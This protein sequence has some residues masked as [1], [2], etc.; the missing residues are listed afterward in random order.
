MLCR[1]IRNL[2]LTV[3]ILAA[4]NADET[5]LAHGVG[6][7][8]LCVGGSLESGGWICVDEYGRNLASVTQNDFVF[9]L[10]CKEILCFVL[11]I[12]TAKIVLQ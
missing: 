9:N 2:V 5:V 6:S 12:R 10:L 11:S 1:K 3:A 7:C 4:R 8:V